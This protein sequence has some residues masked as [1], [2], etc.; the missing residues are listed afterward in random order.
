MFSFTEENFLTVICFVSYLARI[1]NSVNHNSKNVKLL[2][3][4]R[5]TKDIYGVSSDFS[6]LMK[7]FYL[8]RCFQTVL[9]GRM[10]Y[11]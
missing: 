1:Y 9:Q 10:I 4:E 6:K 7:F 8:V 5:K 11:I 3:I 2:Y